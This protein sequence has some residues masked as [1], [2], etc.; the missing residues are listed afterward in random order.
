MKIEDSGGNISSQ[1]VDN[2]SN[3]AGGFLAG[4][5]HQELTK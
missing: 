4:S 1:T 3:K 5:D 2:S